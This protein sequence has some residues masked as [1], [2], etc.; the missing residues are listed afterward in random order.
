MHL[1]QPTFRRL[2]DRVE[3]WFIGS[4]TDESF[5][6]VSGIIRSIYHFSSFILLNDERHT[7]IEFFQPHCVKYCSLF[8]KIVRF[9]SS[10][11]VTTLAGLAN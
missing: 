11:R 7:D 1:L 6:I 3:W 10:L 5:A 9:I 8:S 4:F 2:A